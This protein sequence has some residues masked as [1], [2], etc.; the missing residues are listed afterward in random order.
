MVMNQWALAR[1]F[2]LLACLVR[3]SSL[4]A[5]RHGGSSHSLCVLEHLE[6]PDTL[7]SKPGEDQ[8]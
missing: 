5:I 2:C 7:R 6:I 4:Q 3:S 8:T 1:W